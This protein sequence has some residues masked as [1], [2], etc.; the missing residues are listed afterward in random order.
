MSL[1]PASGLRFQAVACLFFPVFFPSPTA[2]ELYKMKKKGNM[3]YKMFSIF[4]YI[5]Y[6]W[7]IF[8]KASMK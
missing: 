4:I 8:K 6:K 1:V 2:S 3:K 5:L 7:L